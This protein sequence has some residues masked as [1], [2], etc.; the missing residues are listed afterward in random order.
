VAA[1]VNLVRILLLG[2]VEL[3]VGERQA[4]LGGPKQ[5]TLLALLALEAGQTVSRDRAAAALW[6]DSLPE[7]HPQRLHTVVSRLR[8]ALRE[9]GG[10]AEVVET[11]EIGYR[12]RAD[13]G[14]IDAIQ[15]AAALHEARDLRATGRPD[16]A[17]AVAR[18]AIDLWRGPPLA[19]LAD[20]GWAG[21]DLRR[22]DD[23]RLSLLE[24]EFDCRLALGASPGLV[25]ELQAA[26]AAAPL[27]ERLHAQLMLALNANGRRT[28]AL[29]EYDRARRRL[30]EELGIEP[31]AL[32][33]EAHRTVLTEEPDGHQLP[34]SRARRR[35]ARPSRRAIAAAAVLLGAL[36]A[37]AGVLIAARGGPQR[38][39]LRLRAGELV[40]A[41][42]DLQQVRA[43]IPLSGTVIN[44]QP[45]G[46]VLANGSLWSVTEK[47]TVTQVDVV[48]RRIV[49]STPLALPAGPGGMAVG[50][51]A[52]WVTDSASSTLYRLGS[53]VTAAHRIRLPPPVGPTGGVAVAVGSIWVARLAGTV[54]RLS[55][56]GELEHR[57]QI[58]GATQVVS[59]GRAIWVISS[60]SGVVTKVDPR[61]NRVRER[62]RLRP[63]VC[64]LTAGG[65]WVWA[66][67]EARGLLWQLRPDGAVQDV[68][69]VPAPATELA[70]ADGAVWISGYTSG[71]VTRVD[72]ETLKLRTIHTDQPLAGMAAAPEVVA[73]STFASERASL[74]GVQGPV[75]RILMTRDLIGDSDPAAPIIF[76]DRDADWQRQA[77]TCLSLYEY[78]GPRLAADA[79]RGR[80]ARRSNGRVWTFRVRPGFAFSP[81]SGERVDA[82][83]F[84]ATIERSTAPAF[85]RS[86]AAKALAD[87]VGMHAYRRGLTTHL[88]GVK[89]AG[90]RLTIRLKRP[91]ADLDARFA[92][93]YFCAVPKDTPAISTGLQDPI[94]SAGPYYVAGVSGGA[95]EVLRRNPNF[96][97]PT[98]AVFGAFVYE[99]NVDERQAI[100]M[101]EHDQADYAAFY[102]DDL[103]TGLVARP[104]AVGGDSA[105]RV[106][107]SPRPRASS[108]GGRWLRVT[109]LF[110]RHM[111]C[112]SYSALYA[113]VELERLCPAAGGG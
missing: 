70:Y 28:D 29:D 14:Q 78:R 55:R 88:A 62:T 9:A 49:G 20:N 22:L 100:D 58:P 105:L 94:P 72:A 27:R 6:G 91:V 7:G 69:D 85:S 79:A 74:A 33:R 51:G 34:V 42:P 86:E 12:L 35:A 80:A 99:F 11:T 83:T 5:R 110:G 24:E 8:A 102:R 73:F 104:G 106:R 82:G 56:D 17:A 46:L 52:T 75:A 13:A 90:D 77:A 25:D 48:R 41:G 96:R 54:D 39:S 113:G 10:P 19:D 65:G 109:E 59:D 38:A 47:G 40:I 87:V 30:S 67:S 31:G 108:A 98:R 1:T 26:C 21:N 66:T 76:G 107:L 64:C 18:A 92:A 43:E 50:L 93:P 81:P 71:T 63:D 23:L 111:G 89:A 45:G 2:P 60:D 57:F 3:W 53:G 97:Q 95:F 112:L 61:T 36:A 37:T 44:E 103:P 4:A 32:L 101:V 16:E 68:V 15:A 84:A